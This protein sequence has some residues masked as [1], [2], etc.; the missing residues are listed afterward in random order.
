MQPKFSQ[1]YRCESI[2]QYRLSYADTQIQRQNHQN[3]EVAAQSVCQPLTSTLNMY[4][5]V[6]NSVKENSSSK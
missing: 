2:E 4:V 6:S 5:L 1:Q 3:C